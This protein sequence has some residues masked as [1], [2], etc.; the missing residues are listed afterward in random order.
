MEA[1]PKWVEEANAKR[2]KLD[3]SLKWR[4]WTGLLGVELRGLSC[5]P[6]QQEMVDLACAEACAK[7]G[8]PMSSMELAR[9][10]MCDP[11]QSVK[12]CKPLAARLGSLCV[13]SRY[14]WFGQDRT[15]LAADWLGL[16]G[17]EPSLFD[18]CTE[19]VACDLLGE[20]IAVPMMGV[21]MAAILSGQDSSPAAL[22]LRAATAAAA[23][24]HR[25]RRHG[26]LHY[27]LLRCEP[28]HQP[29]YTTPRL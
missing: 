17:F 25:H 29:T 3:M 8:V 15:L 9:N 24:E 1:E 18:D 14:Y 7:A 16:V 13:A 2:V 21:M 5:T 22:R 11:T 19:E 6:R 4:P 28:E 23:L 20:A 12:R 27:S 10:L 26:D